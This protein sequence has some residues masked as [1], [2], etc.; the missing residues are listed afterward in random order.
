M[1]VNMPV[2]K[3]VCADKVFF[4]RSKQETNNPKPDHFFVGW[5]V[6]L[7]AEELLNFI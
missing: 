1:P 6:C 2:N 4:T 5:L 3:N 7:F